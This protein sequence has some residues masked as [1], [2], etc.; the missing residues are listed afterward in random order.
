MLGKGFLG[1]DLALLAHDKAI[2]EIAEIQQRVALR[3]M[4][5]ELF[6]AKALP[7]QDFYRRLLSA[8]QQTLANASELVAKEAK[9]D[10]DR[11]AKLYRIVESL[12][13]T[14]A[15]YHEASDEAWAEGIAAYFHAERKR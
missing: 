7:V 10:E 4:T 15:Q 11:L 9:T 12:E 2:A 3:H 1:K 14:F 6:G 13:V 8:R 5:Q